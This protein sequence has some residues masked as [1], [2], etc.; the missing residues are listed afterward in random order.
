MTL[1]GVGIPLHKQCCGSE[2]Q[3]TKANFVKTT[4]VLL[5]W[6]ALQQPTRQCLQMILLQAH[7]L[8]NLC[9]VGMASLLN[10]VAKMYICGLAMHAQ[11]CLTCNIRC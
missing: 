10:S 4:Q 8:L 3:V 7:F 9:T 1:C 2:S 11:V 5:P 6:S